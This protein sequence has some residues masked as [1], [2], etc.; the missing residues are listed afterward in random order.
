MTRNARKTPGVFLFILLLIAL[1]L[2]AMIIRFQ[3]DHGKRKHDNEPDL[4]ERCLNRHGVAYAFVETAS[5][6]IHLICTE[7]ETEF[8]DVIYKDRGTL[9]GI[10]AFRVQTYTYRGST[11][12]FNTIDEYVDFLVGRGDTLLDPSQF[13]G[14]FAFVWP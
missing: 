8:Y 4:A 6:R 7:S 2:F 5:G 10:T 12:A 11:Y 1:S 9:D 3:T 13:T 14:P